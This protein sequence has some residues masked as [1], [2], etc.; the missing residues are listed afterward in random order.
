[1]IFKVLYVEDDVLDAQALESAFAKTST[2]SDARALEIETISSPSKIDKKLDDSFDVVLADVH[3]RNAEGKEADCLDE[4][5]RAVARWSSANGVTKP[6]PIIAYTGQGS[7]ALEACLK[8][9]EKLYDIWDKSV[10]DPAYVVWRFS[11]LALELSRKRPDALLQKYIRNMHSGARW[12]ER[13]VEM[14]RGYSNAWT[15]LDQI[16]RAGSA[17]NSILES[18][19]TYDSCKQ[20]WQV[21]QQWEA[22][23]RAV[24][25]GTRGHAR[26]VI[27][28]FWLGYYLLNHSMLTG[29]FRKAW[30]N[31]AANRRNASAL[32]NM[33]PEEVL[34]DAWVYAGLFHDV[35]GCV[36]KR[37][38]VE[39][40]ANKLYAVFHQVIPPHQKSD[41]G[42]KM[43]NEWGDSAD[44]LLYDLPEGVRKAVRPG[45][46]SSLA[47]NEPDHGVVAATYL[48]SIKCN[49]DQP[50]CLREAARA[51]AV[52]NLIGKLVATPE[53][54]LSWAAEPLACLLTLCDQLQTWDRERADET[55]MDSDWPNRA[56]LTELKVT[57]KSPGRM[58]LFMAI[59]Y[60][61]PQHLDYDP[62]IFQRVKISLSDILREN[63][64]RTLRR[65]S[66]WP[67]E[68]EI[69]FSLNGQILNTG[70]ELFS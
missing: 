66:D 29:L 4:I 27:N 34:N 2:Q 50:V 33:P 7:A 30:S 45:W 52:H 22:L 40:K 42:G 19:G 28:V 56:E 47:A 3:F 64:N 21:M 25:R 37:K 46:L 35:A 54:L 51:T 59:D 44:E 68:L 36:E 5:I 67:F 41:T 43:P 48:A 13:V 11:Q 62:V 26:H 1:M 61:A 17:I 63:P 20:C 24:S 60:L 23:G 6:L 9:R 15:E 10:A 14:S 32:I 31:A 8:R 16:V 69:R 49:G 39:L 65:I 53:P 18:L 70:I 55:I 12:H 57:Q 58:K 38:D